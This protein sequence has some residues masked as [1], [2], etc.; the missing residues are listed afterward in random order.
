MANENEADK[1]YGDGTLPEDADLNA[2]AAAT[3]DP[4]GADIDSRNPDTDDQVAGEV[5]LDGEEAEEEAD[6]DRAERH[7]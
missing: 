3:A 1:V 7:D 5:V 6:R 4:V 2:S